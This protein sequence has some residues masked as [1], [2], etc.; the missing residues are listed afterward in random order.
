MCTAPDAAHNS[1]VEP[2]APSKSGSNFPYQGQIASDGITAGLEDL[3]LVFF[4]ID[5]RMHHKDTV[6]TVGIE[7]KQLDGL[8]LAISPPKQSQR[9]LKRRS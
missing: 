3:A 7:R 6:F 2:T 4:T 8:F 5:L 1:H 9:S